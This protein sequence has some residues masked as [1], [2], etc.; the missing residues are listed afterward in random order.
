M[1]DKVYI[2]VVTPR[3]I[4][5]DQCKYQGAI[6]EDYSRRT[7]IATLLVDVSEI[8]ADYSVEHHSYLDEAWG[9]VMRINEYTLD[10]AYCRWNDHH[11]INDD[12]VCS[13]LEELK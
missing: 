4:S 8:D 13:R 7:G 1:S 6:V 12:E 9:Q 10:I 3:H 11:I 2:Y 5:D